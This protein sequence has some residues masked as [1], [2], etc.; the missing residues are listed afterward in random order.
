MSARKALVTIAIGDKFQREWTTLCR[1]NWQAYAD[2]H[3]YDLISITSTLDSSE[4][5]QNRNP[6]WQKCLIL[7]QDWSS[8]YDRIVWLD[9]DILI[10]TASAPCVAA[11]VPLEKV[12]GTDYF[13]APVP[14]YARLTLARKYDYWGDMAVQND[15]PQKYY[16]T[17]HIETDLD[18]VIQC[19]VLVFSPKHHRELLEHVYHNY[20]QYVAYEGRA[21]S[22]EIN[23]GG[24]AHWIDERFN[25]IWMNYKTLFYPFFFFF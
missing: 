15:T 13:D 1:N 24:Y 23:K 6:S 17:N 7:S 22:Y 8:Q 12:G 4:R 14:A 11:E 18:K 3:N 20:E 16:R 25:A 21:L 9:A 10:N 19:G 5:G 2:K